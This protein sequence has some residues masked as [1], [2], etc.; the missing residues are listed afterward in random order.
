MQ[1][2]AD[3]LNS[4]DGLNFLE[5]KGVFVNQ[6]QFKDQL[7]APVRSDLIRHFGMEGRKLVC[8]GQQLY[9]DYHQSVLSSFM[10]RP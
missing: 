4:S 7:K 3:L 5:S 10:Q 6:D 1:T 2:L 9:V 8:S